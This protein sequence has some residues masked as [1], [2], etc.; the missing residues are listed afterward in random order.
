VSNKNVELCLFDHFFFYRIPAASNYDAA[1]L[2]HPQDGN[3]MFNIYFCYIVFTCGRFSFGWDLL[4]FMESTP[5]S[6]PNVLFF[7]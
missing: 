4:P 1:M 2:I 3:E 5:L 7:K 6:G